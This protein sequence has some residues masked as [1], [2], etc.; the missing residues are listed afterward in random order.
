LFLLIITS[1]EDMGIEIILQEAEWRS[2][3]LLPCWGIFYVSYGDSDI[4][5]P[6]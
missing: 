6:D 4:F 3:R 1:S 5:T 2:W